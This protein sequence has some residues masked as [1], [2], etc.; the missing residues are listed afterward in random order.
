MCLFNT[1]GSIDPLL[2][3]AIEREQVSTSDADLWFCVTAVLLYK[4]FSQLVLSLLYCGVCRTY[5]KRGR[6]LVLP[7]KKNAYHLD[8]SRP[9]SFRPCHLAAAFL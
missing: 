9:P 3:V 6:R 4:C 2:A 1:V 7:A 8:S 5:E